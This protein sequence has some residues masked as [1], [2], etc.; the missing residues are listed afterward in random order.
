MSICS[1]MSCYI[2]IGL[3]REK[4]GDSAMVLLDISY[5]ALSVLF[6]AVGKPQNGHGGE[7]YRKQRQRAWL[8]KL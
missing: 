2:V 7:A 4:R 1:Q 8:W 3:H 6:R 5:K